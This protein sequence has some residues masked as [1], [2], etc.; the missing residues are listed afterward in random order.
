M[1]VFTREEW[2][3]GF[4]AVGADTIDK[5]KSSFPALR[6]Q[7]NEPAAFRDFYGFCFGFA[8]D[9]GFGVRTLPMEVARELW[10]LTL[11]G[12]FKYL[13]AWLEFCQV[14]HAPPAV[15][16]TPSHKPRPSILRN[17]PSACEVKH[18]GMRTPWHGCGLAL[19]PPPP[20]ALPQIKQVKVVTKDIWEMLLTF[21]ASIK[22]DMSN[23]NE[24]GAWPVR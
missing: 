13:D 20:H 7:L 24:D 14:H 15:V 10:Q 9:P 21:N 5:M 1:C 19:R 17:V 23:F 4:S 3:R 16:A 8:K 11:G 18:V 2:V 22:D 12:R 6:S